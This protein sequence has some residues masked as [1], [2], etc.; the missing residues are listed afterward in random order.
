MIE[1]IVSS[2]ALLAVLILLRQV[3]KG[4]IGLRLQ[5]ALWG[6]ALLRLLVPVSFGS[7]AVSVT[8]ALPD[9]ARTIPERV[10]TGG[11]GRITTHTEVREYTFPEQYEEFRSDSAALSHFGGTGEFV[12]SGSYAESWQPRFVL[13][14]LWIAGMAAVAFCL[15]GSNLRFA[16]RLRKNRKLLRE[17]GL[18]VY[19]TEEADTPC[20]F[21]LFRPAIYVTP[22][23][24]EEE[25]RLRHVIEHELTHYRHGDHLWSLLR[26]L[27]LILHWYNPLVWLAAFLSRRDGELACDE[28]TIRRLGEGERAAYGRTL[29]YMTCAKRP[30]LLVTATT[31]TGSKRGIRERIG[32]IVKRPRTA[33]YTLIAVLLA[34]AVA[35]GCTF[36]GGKPENSEVPETPAPETTPVP[37]ALPTEAADETFLDVAD[38]MIEDYCRRA[39][40]LCREG[41][42]VVRYADGKSVDVFYPTLGRRYTVAVLFTKGADGGWTPAEGVRVIE[43]RDRGFAELIPDLG[44]QTV[45]EPVLR[46]AVKHVQQELDYYE[47]SCGYV[48]DEAKLTG[49][50]QINTG[51]AGLTE[52]VNLYLLEYR[53][54]PAPDQEIMLVGGMTME[55]GYLTEWSS[56]GQPYLLMFVEDAEDG[57]H[58]TKLCVTN[59]DEIMTDYGTPEMIGKYG[60]AYTAAAMELKAKYAGKAGALDPRGISVFSPASSP[61]GIGLDWAEAF[62]AALIEAPEDDPCR[63]EAVELRS[64]EDIAESLLAGHKSFVYTMEFACDPTDE[65]AFLRQ[66]GDGAGMDTEHPDWVRFR[67]FVVLEN[68]Y[69]KGWQCVQAGV[70]GY[71]GWGY[72]NYYWDVEELLDRMVTEQVGGED[73]LMLLPLIDWSEADKSFRFGSDTWNALW[74]KCEEAC[75]SGGWSNYDRSRE[76]SDIYATDQTLR[77]LYVILGFLHSDGAYAEGLA[78]L[79]YKQ[80]RFDTALYDTCLEKCLTE[81]QQRIVRL[82][83]ENERSAADPEEGLRVEREDITLYIGDWYTLPV[84][85][86]HYISASELVWVSDDPEVVSVDAGGTVTALSRGKATITASWGEFQSR[87]VVRVTEGSHKITVQ[88]AVVRFYE[89]PTRE[90]KPPVIENTV[91]YDS[92]NEGDIEVIEALKA[93]IDRIRYWEND[94]MADRVEFYFDGDINFSDRQFTYFFAFDKRTIYYDHYFGQMSRDDAEYLRSL[95]G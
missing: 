20:L 29:L 38:P 67:W 65:A 87:C 70:G 95:A 90:K 71:G 94:D 55:N 25:G 54:R 45:P 64:C 39:G 21:G 26:G 62:A 72:L 40:Q 92:G 79:M 13:S 80:Y 17:E 3:L 88:T 74:K 66:L 68:S 78:S 5:Y 23:A 52:A 93:I 63:C 12:S 8:N 56:V 59:T 4:K 89:G 9:R 86:S 81:D 58:W 11:G 75:I 30:N 24:A 44:D 18:P 7:T 61:T 69:N 36:T 34:A 57:Q 19:L 15:F 84:T 53:F 10:V 41:G 37:S 14:F 32:L 42:T 83:L 35:V 85:L 22:E 51:T 76:G 16:L 46:S 60:N 43:D 49:V 47:T 31:M 91:T 48:F 28:G 50:T 33:V 1:W 73:A 77:N 82:S 6:L 27:C 2:S